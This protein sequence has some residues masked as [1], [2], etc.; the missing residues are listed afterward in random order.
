MK[1]KKSNQWGEWN[2]YDINH[3]KNLK[4]LILSQGY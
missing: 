2:E 1:H 4:Y 3:K